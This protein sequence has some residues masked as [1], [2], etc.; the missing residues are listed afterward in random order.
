MSEQALT[1][2]KMTKRIA[3]GFLKLVLYVAFVATAVYF[4]P[5][6]LSKALNTPYPLAV[7]TS[8]SMWPVLKTNDLV[9]MKG[10]EGSEAQIGQI[11]IYKNQNGFTIHRLIRKENGKLIT[12]GDTN[13]VEDKPIEESDVIGRVLY[14]KNNPLRIPYIGALARSVGPKLTNLSN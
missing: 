3:I 6:I 4:A 8:G 10:I 11:I 2:F 9:F 12:Q 1:A 13:Q 7:I 5:K 14:I